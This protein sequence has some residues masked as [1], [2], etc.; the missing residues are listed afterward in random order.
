[1]MNDN[2]L[3][4]IAPETDSPVTTQNRQARLRRAQGLAT[5]AVLF[6]GSLFLGGPHL[7]VGEFWQRLITAAGEAGMVGGLADWFAV[8]ALFRKPLGLP[9]PHTALIP[10][11]KD[12]IA[13]SLARFIEDHFLDPALL[14]TRLKA[15]DRALQLGEWLSTPNAANFV[16]KRLVSIIRGLVQAGTHLE[17]VDAFIPLLRSVAE[18]LEEGLTREVGRRTGPLIPS[19]V[20]RG[21]ARAGSSMMAGVIK[22]LGTPGSPERAALDHWIRARIA[23]VPE[24]IAQEAQAA[25]ETLKGELLDPTNQAPSELEYALAGLAQRAGETIIKSVPLRD[26]INEAIERLVIDYVV[27]WRHQIGRYIED[28]VRGW[29]AKEVSQIVELQVGHDLQFIRLN[30]TAIGAL[31]GVVLFLAGWALG[32]P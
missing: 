1:M 3:E 27:P 10:N 11:R 12:D 7:P 25:W 30:G 19:L 9:I 14:V 31:I 8:S 2:T 17:L 24:D 15:Q 28:V 22:A 32:H 20:D 6:A 23:E 13:R 4:S 18:G 29:D 26:W 16:A 5:L 21:L